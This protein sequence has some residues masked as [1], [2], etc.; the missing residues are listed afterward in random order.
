MPTSIPVES[1]VH[2]RYSEAARK[3]VDALCCPVDYD[4]GYLR[5]IPPEVLERDYGCGN[6]TRYLRTGE[7]VLDLGSGG[8]KICFIASQVVGA[9]G[10]VIGV[11]MNDDMLAL[12]RKH[13]KA[14][15]DALGWHNVDFR[16]GRIQD[17]A[18]NLELLDAELKM[19]P[20]ASAEALFAVERL[21]G[22]WRAQHPLVAVD[23]VD[24][25]ISNCVLNLVDPRAKS[26]VFQ[27]IFRVLKPGGRAVISD[28][29]SAEEVPAALQRDAELWSGCIA[30]AFTE[31]GFLRAFSDA[32]FCRIR[33]LKREATPWRT[34]RGI[35]FRSLTVEA[36]KGPPDGAPD[37][38]QAGI[39]QGPIKEVRDESSS[40]SSQCC[41]GGNCE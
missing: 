16:K 8:G 27:E 20:V 37:L 18:L 14:V 13:Q 9:A 2:R 25:V 23:S 19:R 22:E 30:G 6:P 21:A 17:L 1:V 7:T 10:Q 15:G 24:V 4:P 5:V 26:R 36:C 11:D 38:S 31:E 35:E 3:K 28:I 40:A 29:A 39:S 34:V 33:I 12:A 41:G 32:G